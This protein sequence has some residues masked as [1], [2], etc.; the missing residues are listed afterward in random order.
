MLQAW[1]RVIALLRQE[2]QAKA[3]AFLVE[4]RPVAWQGEQTLVVEY[5]PDR[6][7]HRDRLEAGYKQPVEKA[8]QALLG[9][10]ISLVTRIAGQGDGGQAGTT[11]TEP[12]YPPAVMEALRLFG[13]RVITPERTDDGP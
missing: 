4:G 13:G 8:F 1:D 7:F 9:R 2:R 11:D 6:R 10:K 12:E 5:P 3:A